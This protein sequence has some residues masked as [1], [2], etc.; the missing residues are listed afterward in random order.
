MSIRENSKFNIFFPYLNFVVLHCIKDEL[1]RRISNLF[2][3]F[4]VLYA[5]DLQAQI[6]A[7]TFSI[8]YI[9]GRFD[10]ATEDGFMEIP[11]EY[12]DQKGRYIRKDVFEAFK[13]MADEAAL[14]GI[15]LVIRSATRNFKAQKRI[16]E[17]KW[18]GKVLLEGNINASKTIKNPT[19]RALKIL[20][21]SSMPG[22][23]RHH[24]GT[25]IDLNSFDNEWFAS[26][27][28]LKLYT[29]MK[30]N[31]AGFGFCQPYTAKGP[32]RPYGYEE[33]K[34]HWTYMPVAEKITAQAE[35]LLSNDH[36]K[37]F[38]GA[39]TA[40][41]IDVIRKYVLGIHPD[42]ILLTGKKGN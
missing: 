38:K 10:P 26:G 29:W 24:W 1:V 32:E 8:G 14:A 5:V 42:C 25:D 18:H 11:V 39:S 21:Y 3:F 27:E 37:G 16:W 7:D 33:E 4:C 22:T 19:F 15:R 2:I 40:V 31:A 23:S 17:N 12:A 35:R 20:E 9:T 6:G 34:W 36:I 13:R 30:E 28:G 41:E